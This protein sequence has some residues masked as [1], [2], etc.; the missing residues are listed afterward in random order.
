SIDGVNWIE[1]TTQTNWASWAHTFTVTAKDVNDNGGIFTIRAR[2]TDAAGND[3]TSLTSLEIDP[4][5]PELSIDYPYDGLQTNTPVIDVRG[6]TERGATVRVNGVEVVLAGTLFL[7]QLALVEGPNTI[8]VAAADALG[9]SMEIKMEVVLDTKP[10]YLVLLTPEE[11]ELF[12]EPT[13]TVSGQAEDDLRI[14]VNDNLLGDAHYGAGTFEYAVSLTRGENMV[15]L[16]SIDLAGNELHVSR[17]VILDDVLPILAVQTPLD[18]SHHNSM[19]I[20][21]FG[22]TDEDAFL[23]INSDLVVLDH[24]LFAYSIVG[25]EGMNEILIITSDEAGNV[26]SETL[27]VYIDT[28]EPTL[29]ITSP[30]GDHELVTNGFFTIAGVAVGAHDVWVNGVIGPVGE[31]GTFS[32][33]IT[34]LEGVNRFIITVADQAGNSVTM[35]RYVTMDTQAPLVVVS[36][37]NLVEKYDKNI[38]KTKKGKPST[39]TITGFTDEAVKVRINGESVPVSTEGYFIIDHTLTVNAENSIT[40]T[41]EDVAGN[42]A[43]WEQTVLHDYIDDGDEDGFDIGILILVVGLIFLAI[44]L[45]VGWKRLTAVEERQEIVVEEDEVLA[46]AMM[47]EVEEEETMV[48]EE[49]EIVVDEEEEEVHEL[50]PPGERPRTDASRPVSEPSDEVTIEIDEKDLEEKDADADVEADESE[51]REEI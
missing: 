43:T 32:V 31:D 33:P 46:P 16:R 10:P 36:I 37:P 24:G 5:P 18:G 20:D 48:D 15:T 51:Q 35:N 21:V 2:A 26:V 29:V 47:P 8:T 44:A 1:P 22:T 23:L 41:A 7:T 17:I 45:L 34:L 40:I 4:F 6:V 49:E 25:V 39:M 50:T 9:N 12:N 42:E 13:S 38:Y 11:G 3:A 27:T 19:T 14:W 28:Q 30:E